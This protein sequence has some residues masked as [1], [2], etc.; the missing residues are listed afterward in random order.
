MKREVVRV[1]APFTDLERCEAPIS[2]VIEH[3]AAKLHQVRPR[4]RRGSGQS[5]CEARE[6][7]LRVELSSEAAEITI[8]LDNG[9]AAPARRRT[10]MFSAPGASRLH[11]SHERSEDVIVMVDYLAHFKSTLTALRDE[12]AT[13]FLPTLSAEPATFRM[14]SGTARSARGRS[15]SGAPT[16]TS[17]W[18]NTGG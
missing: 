1:K 16:I 3:R 8:E 7:E 15:S 14:R 12:P 18:G 6:C 11:N 4:L 10:R 2:A 5:D 9:A 13:A 17:A